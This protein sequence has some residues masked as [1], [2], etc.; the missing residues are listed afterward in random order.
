M[1]DTYIYILQ[2]RSCSRW[3]LQTGPERVDYSRLPFFAL[4]ITHWTLRPTTF[5]SDLSD[6]ISAPE[7]HPGLLQGLRNRAFASRFLFGFSASFAVMF[8]RLT[9]HFSCL[10]AFLSLWFLRTL[11]KSLHQHNGVSTFLALGTLLASWSI[12]LAIKK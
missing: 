5:N 8:N 12:L 3:L 4:P 9:K 6:S 1:S 2:E 7:K 11:E 10:K